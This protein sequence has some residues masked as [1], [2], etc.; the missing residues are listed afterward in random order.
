MGLPHQLSEYK[1]KVIMIV[2]TASKCG[3]TK[4][5]ADLQKLWETYGKD[6]LVIL[7]F[8]A[9]N[10]MNQEPGSDTE[11]Q[12]FCQLNYGVSFPMFAKISVKGKDIHPLFAY[13]TD[14]KAGHDHG[15]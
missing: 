11:I 4:Q 10:F 2:N 6:G 5:Y 3:F 8:P 9:N 15:G 1:G 13:L 12:N 14:K 7:G